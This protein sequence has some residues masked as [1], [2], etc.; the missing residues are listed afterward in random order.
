MNRNLVVAPSVLKATAVPAHPL[1]AGHPFA[2]TAQR[3]GPGG[4]PTNESRI[5]PVPPGVVRAPA[6]RAPLGV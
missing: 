1:A 2:A 5:A 6:R 3:N 4:H